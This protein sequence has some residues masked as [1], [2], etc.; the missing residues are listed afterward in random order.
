MSSVPAPSLDRALAALRKGRLVIITDP[1]RPGRGAVLA[2]AADRA[3]D[4]GVNF[5]VTH[6]RGPVVCLA[7]PPDRLERLG[8]TLQA[9]KPPADLD[10][11]QYTISI[12]ARDGVSTG[13]SA[14]DRA[15]TLQV[16]ADRRTRAEDLVTPGHLFPVLAD[17][18]GVL[19]RA[20]WAEAAVDLARIA[21]L[22]PA[23]GMCHILT[24]D[25]E[26]PDANYID[27]MAAEYRLPVVR[28]AGIVA[29]RLA[30]ET[31]V[32]QLVQSILPT[33]WGDFTCRVFVNELDG[34]QHLALSV[35]DIRGGAPVLTR[36]HSECLTGDILGSM[37]CDCGTQL[38][39]A[40]ERIAESGRGVLLYLRQEGRGIGLVN[41]VN[42]YAL[43][44]AG[45]DTVEANLELGFDADPRDFSLGA[46][47]LSSL[48]VDRVCLM[49]NNPHK[50]QALRAFGVEVASRDPLEFAPCE[51]NV[52]YLR[53]KKIKLGHLL[54]KV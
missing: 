19:I 13:I 41:K 51:H 4:D 33:R 36:V 20:G 11:E 48:G 2:G 34:K 21:G 25:G 38:S 8:L 6:G 47:M 27:A 35:G 39:V 9:Q 50:V 28:V 30:T 17:P 42:A 53:A 24:P 5:M 31:F 26:N 15:R 46:Q 7:L 44:D 52:D 43:Q 18:R 16:A 49:T 1:D 29:H 40:M 10:V 14:A 54:T 22:Q 45:R 37:R 23:M 32:A 3:T 12:E